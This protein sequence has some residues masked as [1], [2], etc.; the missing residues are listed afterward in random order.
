MGKKI[1][2]SGWLSSKYGSTLFLVLWKKPYGNS[3]NNIDIATE[4]KKQQ[5][6]QNPKAVKFCANTKEHAG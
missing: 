1:I 4:K 6:S 2:F 5:Q 3:I